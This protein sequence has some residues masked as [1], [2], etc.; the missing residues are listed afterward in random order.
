MEILWGL[1]SQTIF[2][3]TKLIAWLQATFQP[4]LIG[5][6]LGL[7]RYSE[8][9]VLAPLLFAS[10]PKTR[11]KL[12]QRLVIGLGLAWSVGM[13]FG[14][15]RPPS[16]F[17]LMDV[18]SRFAG[19][20]AIYGFPSGDALAYG[21]F[22]IIILTTA[23]GT[24]RYQRL[25][26]VVFAIG[27]SLWIVLG[28][29]YLGVH[30]LGDTLFGFTAGICLGLIMVRL[31]QTPRQLGKAIFLL[32]V[33]DTLI[34]RLVFDAPIDWPRALLVAA[35]GLSFAVLG[36]MRTSA[37]RINLLALLITVLLSGV[38]TQFP[39]ALS[40][41]YLWTISYPHLVNTLPSLLL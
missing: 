36:A 20:S 4:N 3:S 14:W 19:P 21:A 34:V 15:P 5:N 23:W 11:L 35:I 32:L 1:L 2:F 28:R 16:D 13:K 38:T 17:W 6:I 9:L 37:F 26:K 24:N 40:L 18:S 8:I 41:T 10:F 27:A 7:S 25:L 29:V 33:L 39:L 22:L 12:G 30:Y 31:E